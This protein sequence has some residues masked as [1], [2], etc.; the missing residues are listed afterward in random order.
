MR[1]GPP[2]L[3]RPQSCDWGG[4]L[5]EPGCWAAELGFGEFWA[6]SGKQNAFADQFNIKSVAAPPPRPHD[7]NVMGVWPCFQV[8]GLSSCGAVVPAVCF[9]VWF[10]FGQPLPPPQLWAERWSRSWAG[11]LWPPS[12]RAEGAEGWGVC[13]ETAWNACWAW[14]VTLGESAGSLAG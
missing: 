12:W 13:M 8:W 1:A 10:H 2:D 5:V 7:L 14:R 6:S 4:F 3:L 11:G 9:Q